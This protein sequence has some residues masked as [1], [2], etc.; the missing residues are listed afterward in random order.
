M[1]AKYILPALAALS[2]V[3]AACSITSTTTIVNPAGASALATCTTFTG[4]IVMAT[5]VANAGMVDISGIE[6]IDGS[7]TYENDN[8]VTSFTASQLQSV[9]DITFMNLTQLST[10]S[11]PALATVGNLDFEGLNLG[12]LGFGTPGIQSATTIRI[13]NTNIGDLSGINSISKVGGILLSDNQFLSSVNFSFSTIKTTFEVDINEKNNG[14]QSVSL[15]NL[16]T[17]GQIIIRNSSSLSIPKLSSVSG[18]LGLYGNS[19][20]S[21][22]FSNLSYVGALVIN[23]NTKLANTSFPMLSVINGTNATMQIANNTK[24]DAISGFPLL[25]TVDGNVNLYGAFDSVDLPTL[26]KAGTGSVSG[27]MDVETSSTKLDCTDINGLGSNGDQVVKGSVTCNSAESDPGSASSSQTASGTGPSA[28]STSS[29]AAV[30]NMQIPLSVAI[31]STSIFAGL[32][33]LIM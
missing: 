22:Q 8:S 10:I 14:G 9:G 25:K 4:D 16:E 26:E 11:A 1:A 27:A 31:G 30:A 17:A 28:T 23:D 20:D 19:L 18:T 3:N 33:Q 24:L 13:V 15:P 21:V 2:T 29:G 7:L 5:G 6:K 32:L 12:S